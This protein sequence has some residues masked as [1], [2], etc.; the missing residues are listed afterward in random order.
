M[1]GTGVHCLEV[2]SVR[3]MSH[4]CISAIFADEIVRDDSLEGVQNIE[5]A[6]SEEKH[7]QLHIVKESSSK[8]TLQQASS[9]SAKRNKRS[10]LI[11]N[12]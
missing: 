8:N 5:E 1:S 12:L 3:Y 11:Y 4:I 9:S 7:P 6:T 10:A 2:C